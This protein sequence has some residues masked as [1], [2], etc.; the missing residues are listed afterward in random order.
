MGCRLRRLPAHLRGSWRFGQERGLFRQRPPLPDRQWDKTARLWDAD[1]A[2]CLLTFEGHSRPVSSVAFS[3]DGRCC[4]TGSGDNTA[5]LWDVDSGACLLT[6]EG[7]GDS[8]SS[9]AF[10]ANGR[11]CLTG[12]GDN[13]ARLWDADSGA[14]LLTFE[15]HGDWVSSVAFSA[16]GRRCLTGSLDNTARLWDAA[17]GQCQAWLWAEGGDWFSLDGTRLDKDGCVVGDGPLLRAG[18]RGAQRLRFADSGEKPA[19]WPW[20]PRLWP[21]ADLPDLLE[22]TA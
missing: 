18:G 20:I 3:A 4:L 21:A 13:T 22:P 9:V 5:R 14:C 10:S 11:R 12:S 16:D 6:F 2:A 19:P 8:V 1:S 7:H 15:G 17:C